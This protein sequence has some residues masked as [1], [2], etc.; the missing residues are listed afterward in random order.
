ML[1]AVVILL[2]VTG[3]SSASSVNQEFSDFTT[4][5]PLKPGDTL[6]L[7]IVGGWERWDAPQRGVRKTALQ[8]RDLKLPGVY[9]E[10][11]ENHKLDLGEELV[12]KAF[13]HDPVHNVRVILY[14]HSLGGMAAIRF[15]RMLN[16]KQIPVLALVSVD[17]IGHNQPVPPNV[18]MVA[19]F[20]QRDSCPVCGATRIRA[21]DPARTT[22][23]GNFQWKYR[24]KYVD[25]HT[26][27]WVRRFFVR[28]HEKMEFDPDM[29]AEVKKILLQ[30]VAK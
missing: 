17:A 10:T 9:I 6:I 13:P 20:Y 7:G 22:I 24:H 21:E 27:P 16:D 29:W 11:V 1:R 12:A 19:N 26:E 23:L 28:G 14:G 3:C 8:L 15:A 25:I 18:R 4:P 2:L 5:L 30:A